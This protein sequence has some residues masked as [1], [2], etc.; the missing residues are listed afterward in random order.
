[1]LPT[2]LILSSVLHHNSDVFNSNI[3]IETFTTLELLPVRGGRVTYFSFMC[4]KEVLAI[5]FLE[6]KNEDRISCNQLFGS[7]SFLF[8]CLQR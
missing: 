7:S 3:S 5:I 4:Y 1:M 2:H 6:K 8:S